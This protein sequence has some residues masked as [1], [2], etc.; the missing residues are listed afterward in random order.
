[1]KELEH[2]KCLQEL[3]EAALKETPGVRRRRRQQRCGRV[4]LA[5]EVAS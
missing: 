2:V 5:S 3:T 4:A 1:M